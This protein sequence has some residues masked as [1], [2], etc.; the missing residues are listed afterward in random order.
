[1]NHGRLY[2]QS[3]ASLGSRRFMPPIAGLSL[4][5][6]LLYLL[7][8]SW[9][10]WGNLVVDSGREV[11]VPER[12]LSGSILYKDI[13][14]PYGPLS[15]YLHAWLCKIFGLHLITFIASGITT[16]ILAAICVYAIARIYI[17]V[18]EASLVALTFLSVFAFG[19]YY[20]LGIFN[21]VIPYSYAATQSLALALL[22][23]C[24]LYYELRRPRRLVQLGIGLLLLLV[25][26]ARIEVGFILG[27]GLLLGMALD[28]DYRLW[29][30]RMLCS[31]LIPWVTAA[32]VYG[33][34][35]LLAGERLEALSA[36]FFANLQTRNP[37]TDWL[38]G[39]EELSANLSAAAHTAG[40]YLAFCGLAFGSDV[41]C[42]K[43]PDWAR[44]CLVGASATFACLI[45]YAVWFLPMQ[46]QYLPTPLFCL[47]LMAIAIIRL[48]KGGDRPRTLLLGAFSFFSFAMLVRMLFRCWAGHYGFYLLVAGSICYYLF[49]L[50]FFAPLLKNRHV[51]LL[52]R[53][54]FVALAAIFLQAHIR[55]SV[56]NYQGRTAMLQTDRGRMDLF[57]Y[58]KNLA[59][60]ARYIRWET[61]AS[62][63]LVVFP[64]GAMYNFL[65]QRTHPLYY[66]SFLPID[67]LQPDFQVRALEDFKQSKVDYVAIVPRDT[68]EY[69]K[70]GFG[71]DY[72]EDMYDY[73]MGH[74]KPVARWRGSME[75]GAPGA[76]LMKRIDE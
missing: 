20:Q 22:A 57:P 13:M 64:E 19:N 67:F 26:L 61:P 35:R 44:F 54:A 69:G 76:V 68:R 50:H 24:L 21:F 17:T 42:R 75:E 56:K 9:N 30:Q 70:R 72:A 8:V 45:L 31:V 59:A 66:Y 47:A 12:I 60:L 29:F 55:V 38:L 53:L 48:R 11:M 39:T 62:A 65:T 58:Y 7:A 51:Q 32:A 41:L 14:Y 5:A 1:M 10:R 16:T 73:L 27:C 3:T 71:T 63:T 37:F 28:R 46:N 2:L 40:Y 36:I 33:M 6:A 23:F 18:A 25:S 34:F 4:L 15:P 52:F 49:F 74:Y 43:Y